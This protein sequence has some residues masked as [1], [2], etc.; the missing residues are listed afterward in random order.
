LPTLVLASKNRHKLVE[1]ADMLQEVNVTVR[2]VTDYPEFPDVV[3]DGNTF[4]ANAAKKALAAARYAN[5]WALADDSGLEVDALGGQPGV[6]S[7]RF[8]GEPSDDAR[9]NS[10]LL[11]AMRGVAPRDRSARFKSVIALA[12]PD[13]NVECVEGTCEGIIGYRL[14]GD[15]GF[16]YDPLFIVPVLGKTFAQLTAEE[17]NAISH[18]GR[19]IQALKS[20][21]INLFG[22]QSH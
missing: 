20:R 18:R 5:E 11:L 14:V 15:C 1:L 12:S 9:N 19:A 21:L 17:K 2:P 4:A 10:K 16:G 22:L 6:L 13:G 7:A 8:A 3:E